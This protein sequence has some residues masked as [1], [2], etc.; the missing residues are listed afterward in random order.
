MV[1]QREAGV[2]LPDGRVI[3]GNRRFTC[4]RKLHREYPNDEKF[5]YFLAAIIR[6]DGQQ[7]TN[8]LL[9]EWFLYSVRFWKMRI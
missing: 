6:V 7:I 4:L 5:S 1:G 9:K 2:V 8:K 3:D